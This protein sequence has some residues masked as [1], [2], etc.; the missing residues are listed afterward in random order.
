MLTTLPTY[1]AMSDLGVASVAGNKMTMCMGRG[2]VDEAR[3]IFQSALLL[4]FS[5][6]SI[7][8]VV[9]AITIVAISPES[10]NAA[11]RKDILFLI[12]FSALLCISNGLFDALFKAHSKYAVGTYLITTGRVTEWG[13]G[14]I[15]LVLF[16]DMIYVAIGYFLGRLLMTIVTLAYVLIKFS[17]FKWSFR[18]ADKG[19]IKDMIKPA[20]AF[21]AIPLGNSISLQGIIIIIGMTLGP[22]TV[23]VFSAYRTIARI[24]VQGANVLCKPLWPEYSNLFGL[25]QFRKLKRIFVYACGANIALIALCSAVIYVLAGQILEFWTSGEIEFVGSLFFVILAASGV[26]GFS[27]MPVTLLAAT[28]QHSHYSLTFLFVSIVTSA[29]SYALASDLGILGLTYIMVAAEVFLFLFSLFI[30]KI[31]VFSMSDSIPKAT[32]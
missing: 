24:L 9:S 8:A 12:V 27:Q 28:N 2:E 13:F 10:L 29:V 15:G 22:A 6:V 26:S 5:V 25:G 23:V 19:I 7:L 17:S 20:L 18:G 1:F 4:V 21:M 31:K 14:I 3:R 32:C 11:I 30:I 16:H